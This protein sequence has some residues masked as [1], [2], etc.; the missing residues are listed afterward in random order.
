MTKEQIAQLTPQE[1]RKFYTNN[2]EGRPPKFNYAG[3]E[4]YEE[5]YNLAMQGATNS[6]IAAGLADRFAETLTADTFSLMVKGRYSHWTAEQN[7]EYGGRLR[8]VLAQARE[9][10]NKIVRGRYLKAALGGIKT[11]NRTTRRLRINGELTDDEEIQTTE[12]ELPPNM[13][14]LST[15]L[16]H[17][18]PEWRRIQRGEIEENKEAEKGIDIDKWIEQEVGL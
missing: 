10:I 1:R 11:K 5:I 16:Y 2:P 17:H 14:A 3:D 4:F 9:N 6:E 12:I 7:E 13:Q 15:W 8:R 18:D